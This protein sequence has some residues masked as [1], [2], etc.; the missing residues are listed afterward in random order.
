MSPE[1]RGR[2]FEALTPHQQTKESVWRLVIEE[3]KASN[4][5]VDAFCEARSL[6]P[7]SLYHW[8][9]ELEQ[10]D[11]ARQLVSR[12]AV[13]LPLFVP[14]K[15]RASEAQPLSAQRA[16]VPGAARRDW[17]LEIELAGGRRVR[18]VGDVD[19]ALLAKVVT[20]LE[21]LAC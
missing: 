11:R 8:R 12:Q 14:V 15:V 16:D 9:R 2:P 10:R 5:G 3:W 6:S 17:A 4:L 21:G 20:V 7:W 13:A 1:R 18:I 19:G